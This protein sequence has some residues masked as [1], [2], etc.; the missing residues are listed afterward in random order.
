MI[1]HPCVGVIVLLSSEPVLRLVNRVCLIGPGLM[2]GSY[3][4]KT[5]W[6]DL[7]V[8]PSS[9]SGTSVVQ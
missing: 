4:A 2:N 9:Q 7:L 8:L 5:A 6:T 1:V 3:G